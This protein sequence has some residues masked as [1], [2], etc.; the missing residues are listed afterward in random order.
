MNILDADGDTPLHY[1]ESEDVVR[2]LVE[3]LGS[4]VGARN[5]EGVTAEEKIREEGEGSW[6]VGVLEYL[7]FKRGVLQ[8]DGDVEDAPGSSV[9]SRPGMV[10]E[11]VEVKFG[12]MQELPEQE[13]DP[14]FRRRIEELASK[15]DLDS[16]EAQRE[17]KKLVEDVVS[18]IRD[19]EGRD[20][21]RRRIDE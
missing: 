10:P 4:D 14:E 7:Q 11:N 17:L 12:T 21:Q 18:G 3:E 8:N 15:G 5:V 1:A 19:D 20:T 2:C 9:L 13:A 6:V 16:E